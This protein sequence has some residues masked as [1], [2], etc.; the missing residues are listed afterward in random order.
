MKFTII[1]SALSGNKGAAAM[2]ESSLQTLGEKYP[3]AH[4]TLLSM[5]PAEDRRLNTYSNLTILPATPLWIGLVLNPAA[6]TYRLLPPLRKFLLRRI[7]QLRSIR[8]SDALLDQGGITFSDGREKFLLYNVASIL[9]ALFVKTPVIK[10]AQALGLFNKRFNRFVSRRILP[11][12]ALIIA[13]GKTTYQNLEQLGLTNI[14]LA[15]DYAFS[16][17]LTESARQ[18]ATELLATVLPKMQ[19]FDQRVVGIS[20]SEVVKKKCEKRGIEYVGLMRWF[21]NELIARGYAVLIIPHSVRT[22]EQ[23]PH[24]ND[25][26]LCQTIYAGVTNKAA[27]G[28]I[29]REVDSQVLR[30]IIGEC[31]LFVACRFHAMVSALAMSV[32]TLVLGWSHKYK[33]VMEQ[34]G[35]KEFSVDVATLGRDTLMASFEGL[36]SQRQKVALQLAEAFPSVRQ[37]SL[38]HVALIEQALRR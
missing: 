20:P 11:R 12:M 24:N 1:G 37:Q 25:L 31:D 2:L 19:Q 23:K 6:L 15:S 7:P 14:V 30:A 38:R 34:F 29:D 22:G 36:V 4:F 3:E 33:E 28:F 27:C 32:P 17:R 16:L 10:C 9:P 21:I 5:Y 18:T 26:P 13:R 8:E 35:I